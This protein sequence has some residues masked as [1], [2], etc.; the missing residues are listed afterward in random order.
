MRSKARVRRPLPAN[1]DDRNLQQGQLAA[2]APNFDFTVENRKL[3]LNYQNVASAQV[4]Y[5]LMDI[6]LMFSQ[7]PVPRPFHRPVLFH[8]AQRRRRGEAGS[9]PKRPR[10]LTC[11]SVSLTSNVMIEITANGISRTQTYYPP[12][13]STSR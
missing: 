2:N 12:T 1:P 9:G 8:S 5:Y 6:E 4:N 3:T 11:P 7:K 10:R 13:P